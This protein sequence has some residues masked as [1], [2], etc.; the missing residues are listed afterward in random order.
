MVLWEGLEQ[1]VAGDSKPKWSWRTGLWLVENLS[2]PSLRILWAGE[3]RDPRGNADLAG[4]V[5][6]PAEGL[7][8]VPEDLGLITRDHIN[9]AW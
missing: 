6:Q 4:G 1:M 5:T 2:V 3:E 7:P 9:Q 8:S